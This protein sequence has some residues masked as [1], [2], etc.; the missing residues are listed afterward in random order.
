MLTD[1][2][3]STEGDLQGVVA[4]GVNRFLGIPYA[5]PPVGEL[6]WQ[7]PRDV[8]RW[9]QTL[10]ATRFGNTC[11][12]PQ[13]GVFAAPSNTEDCLY[14][15]VFAPASKPAQPANATT[16]TAASWPAA[17]TSLS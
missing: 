16:T 4:D 12:Q 2:I 9:T 7:P 3:R 8:T 6:R 5:A 1:V 14:L 10:Q 13:R 11:A 15:N 17:A